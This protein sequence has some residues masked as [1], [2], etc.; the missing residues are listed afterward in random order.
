MIYRES[1]I[2]SL[3]SLPNSRARKITSAFLTDPNIVLLHPAQRRVKKKKID[4]SQQ[5]HTLAI[6]FV[7]CCKL[8]LRV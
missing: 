4:R 7:D 8:S 6:K 2:Q 1:K 5:N 3:H